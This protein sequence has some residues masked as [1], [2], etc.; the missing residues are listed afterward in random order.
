MIVLWRAIVFAAPAGA[1]IWLISN[2]F[3]GDIS[4]AALAN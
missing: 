2:I 3:I 4:I 1:I